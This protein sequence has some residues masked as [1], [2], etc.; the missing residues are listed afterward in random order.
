[1]PPFPLQLMW[2]MYCST[3]VIERMVLTLMR[4]YVVYDGH[5]GIIKIEEMAEDLASDFCFSRL[6]AQ[7]KLVETDLN[8]F[9]S[10][11]SRSS[12]TSGAVLR[13][14]SS[15]SWLTDAPVIVVHR[16]A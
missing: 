4:Q 16:R 6:S 9:E 7:K 14:F 8:A 11:A 12:C 13:Q 10:R 3:I 2:S 15:S 1:M 5:L